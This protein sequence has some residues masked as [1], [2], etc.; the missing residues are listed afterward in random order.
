[1]PTLR[2]PLLLGSQSAVRADI[3]RSIKLPFSAVTSPYDEESE[4][5]IVSR[6]SPDQQAQHLAQGKAAALSPVYS[7]TLILAADQ[8]CECEGSILSKPGSTESAQQQLRFLS[9]KIHYQHSAVCLMLNGEVVWN[10]ITIAE[11]A[12]RALSDDEITHYVA[13]DE[14]FSSCGSY[15]LEKHGKH[16]F[17]SIK[18]NDDVIKGLPSIELLNALYE[19]GFLKL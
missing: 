16:L 9:G 17:S 3:L 2:F 11:L 10:F 6:L 13:L 5:Q 12:M 18:G 4:K 7:D 19:K 15:M 1:M 8:I 14:P